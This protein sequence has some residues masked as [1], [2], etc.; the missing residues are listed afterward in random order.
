MF[1]NQHLTQRTQ[2]SNNSKK[3]RLGCYFLVFN[4]NLF[5]FIIFIKIIVVIAAST[6]WQSVRTG[7]SYLPNASADAALIL[8][9][10]SR[11]IMLL[12]LFSIGSRLVGEWKFYNLL[13]ISFNKFNNFNCRINQFAVES[14]F[15][16][17]KW[18]SNFFH[19]CN[20]IYLFFDHNLIN[21]SNFRNK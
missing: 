2:R 8:I 20:V 19:N 17:G 16:G 18:F 12:I 7:E 5:I 6:K 10:S 14:R 9:S 1:V 13:M 3:K 21:K 15:I 4:L 11:F